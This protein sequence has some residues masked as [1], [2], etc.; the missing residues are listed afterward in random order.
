ML[1][2]S[3]HECAGHLVVMSLLDAKIKMGNYFLSVKSDI[4]LNNYPYFPRE[5]IFTEPDIL[6]SPCRAVKGK[7]YIILM[8][9]MLI[10]SSK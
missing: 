4:L 1:S 10:E 9:C 7:I 6:I 2:F 3:L 5:L 8:V